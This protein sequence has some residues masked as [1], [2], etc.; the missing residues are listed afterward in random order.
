MLWLIYGEKR[1]AGAEKK[2]DCTRAKVQIDT[3]INDIC[4][5][6]S[7]KSGALLDESTTGSLTQ[8]RTSRRCRGNEWISSGLSQHRT[9]A[10]YLF[11]IETNIVHQ[12]W[13]VQSAVHWREMLTPIK[14]Y[15]RSTIFFRYL[16]RTKLTKTGTEHSCFHALMTPLMDQV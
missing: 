13:V 5:L 11:H 6:R 16:F 9:F 10:T 7:T 3:T 14:F 8:T 1:V 15:F 2:K 4:Q 12:S